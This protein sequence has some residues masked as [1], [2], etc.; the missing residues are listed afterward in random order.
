MNG[1]HPTGAALTLLSAA[2]TQLVGGTA[3]THMAVRLAGDASP[4]LG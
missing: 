3:L 1:L 4:N 2:V